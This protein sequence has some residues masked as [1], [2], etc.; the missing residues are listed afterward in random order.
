MSTRPSK[1]LLV[2]VAV[3]AFAAA[4]VARS[5]VRSP[6]VSPNWAG[7]AATASS[8][9][10]VAFTRVAGAWREPS[11]GCDA[12]DAGAASAVWV[13]LGG[14]SGSIR[15]VEQVGTNAN[16]DGADKPVYFAWFEVVPYPAYTIAF[17]VEPG[18]MIGASVQIVPRAVRLRLEDRT[19]GWVFDRTISWASP[20]TSSAEWIVEAPATC[21]RFAC[22][23]PSLA[24]F[25]SVRI[26]QIG[27]IGNSHA[28]TLGDPSWRVTPIRL[29]PATL[30]SRLTL[31]GPSDEGG[32]TRVAHVPTDTAGAVPGAIAADGSAFIV[33]RLPSPGE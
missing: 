33:S 1:L 6:A 23:Q 16:C 11:V 26:T 24:D 32:T 7:Y 28:G 21:K 2:I 5:A 12:D 19:R 3:A 31:G 18:D 27:L 15:K 13:G 4:A 10:R 20:D 22:S 14:Y 29:V 17:R 9:A 25:G 8:H 30:R